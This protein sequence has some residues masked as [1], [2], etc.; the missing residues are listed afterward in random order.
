MASSLVMNECNMK[1][2]ILFLGLVLLLTGCNCRN[3]A[4]KII[5]PMNP[6]TDAFLSC[7]QLKFAIAEAEYF[8]RAADRKVDNA[9]AYAGN[10]LCMIET[11][12]SIIKAQEAAKDRLDYLRTVSEEKKCSAAK[13]IVEKSADKDV[14]K[15]PVQK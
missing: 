6:K 13:K 1:N 7:G 2:K 5:D 3:Q 14:V 8:L 10:P 15:L 9:E 4:I 12:F 11:Q